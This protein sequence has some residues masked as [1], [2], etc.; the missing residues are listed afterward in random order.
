MTYK[1]KDTFLMGLLNLLM[2]VDAT[3]KFAKYMTYKHKDTTNM[4]KDQ[5]ARL[6]R[7]LSFSSSTT[8]HIAVHHGDEAP[9][10]QK[11]LQRRL[12]GQKLAAAREPLIEVYPNA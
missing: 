3:A 12:T 6:S 1:H 7:A 8:S 9:P 4:S 5:K 2:V 10:A 11:V